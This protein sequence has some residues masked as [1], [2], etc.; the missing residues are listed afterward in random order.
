MAKI[1]CILCGQELRQR[2]DKNGKPYFICD[3]CG[4]Q[5]FVRG[6]QGIENLAQLIATLREHDFPFREH[7]RVLYD[8]QAILTEIRGIKKEM[9][10]LDSVFD[11]LASDKD[12]R[13]KARA[14]KSLNARVEVLL[15]QLEQIAC[16]DAQS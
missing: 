14:R 13:D 5:I 7:A 3:P 11:L 1:R 16:T 6:R 12:N 4:M 9:K 15:L 8:I 10:K 2:K